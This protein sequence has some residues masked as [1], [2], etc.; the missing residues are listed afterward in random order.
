MCEPASYRRLTIQDGL[1][2]PAPPL[3]DGAAANV[4]AKAIKAIGAAIDRDVAVLGLPDVQAAVR[5]ALH[6]DS[7]SVREAAVD[8]FG[9]CAVGGGVEMSG[10]GCQRVWET[11]NIVY[12]AQQYGRAAALG[13]LGEYDACRWIHTFKRVRT[14]RAL[15]TTRR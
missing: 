6:D 13:V 9:R 14:Y 11:G 4:R 8:L 15:K 2:H 10:C 3:Q 7:V 5:E 12:P 1:T